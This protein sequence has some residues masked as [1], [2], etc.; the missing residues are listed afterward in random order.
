[1]EDVSAK[2][3]KNRL[4]ELIERVERGEVVRIRRRGKFVALLTG[5]KRQAK[6]IELD[7]LRALTESQ[8][9]QREPARNWLSSA[10]DEAR[11]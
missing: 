2:E 1:M 7:A 8:A 3:A 10:R 5:V 11:Y 9:A 6:P 4:S